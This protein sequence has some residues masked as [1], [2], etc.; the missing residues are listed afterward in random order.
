MKSSDVRGISPTVAKIINIATF[1]HQSNYEASRK[2]PLFLLKPQDISS[3]LCTSLFN[4][5]HPPFPHQHHGQLPRLHLW[6]RARQSQLLL[7][8]QNRRLPARRPL[9]TQARQ[10]FLFA[11]HP[12][13]QSLPEPCLRPQEQDEPV[14]APEPLRRLLR[15]LLVRDVQVRRDRGGSGVR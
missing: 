11:D 5:L 9:L 4:S 8:L 13:A 14:A 3:L 6:H 10:A 15:G 7:L 12:A 2:P 1:N